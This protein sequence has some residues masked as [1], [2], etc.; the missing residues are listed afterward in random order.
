MKLGP[1]VS[2]WVGPG[3]LTL[4]PGV[5]APGSSVQLLYRTSESGHWTHSIVNGSRSAL[6]RDE[7]MQVKVRGDKLLRVRKGLEVVLPSAASVKEFLGEAD[8]ETV[9]KLAG[10]SEIDLPLV[11]KL[12]GYREGVTVTWFCSQKLMR[13]LAWLRLWRYWASC[14]HDV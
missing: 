12:M 8:F 14:Y 2:K 9:K 3:V 7:Q 10:G 5:Y 11:S 1:T 4:E 6:T 13:C